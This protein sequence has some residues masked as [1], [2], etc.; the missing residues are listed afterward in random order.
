M[1]QNKRLKLKNSP[2]YLQGILF[3]SSEHFIAIFQKS[4]LE[5][6]RECPYLNLA[7]R[8]F[9]IHIRVT[10]KLFRD[11]KVPEHALDRTHRNHSPFCFFT[12]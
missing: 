2:P 10:I 4:R 12:N 6:L 8:K 7:V 3:D 11:A 9:L 1:M 5:V